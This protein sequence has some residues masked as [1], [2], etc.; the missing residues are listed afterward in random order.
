MNIIPGK[1]VQ[2]FNF[3][4]RTLLILKGDFM[5]KKKDPFIPTVPTPEQHD[6]VVKYVLKNTRY[7]DEEGNYKIQAPEPVVVAEKT[8]IP[9]DIVRISGI[10]TQLFW[11]SQANKIQGT[12][13]ANSYEAIN[14]GF[15]HSYLNDTKGIKL[16]E[17]GKFGNKKEN[18]MTPQEI[19]VSEELHE[20]ASAFNQFGNKCKHQW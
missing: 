10:E 8:K 5:K 11:H 4:L 9:L 2:F 1:N 12:N 15:C 16:H 6:K 19:N 13:I 17:F 20:I 3:L 7:W 18:S 14:N